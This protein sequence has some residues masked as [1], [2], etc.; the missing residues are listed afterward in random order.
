MVKSETPKPKNEKESNDKKKKKSNNDK[1]EKKPPND[2]KEKPSTKSVIPVVTNTPAALPGVPPVII[3]TKGILKEVSKK[4]KVVPAD[5]KQT[6][7]LTDKKLIKFLDELKYSNKKLFGNQFKPL[8]RRADCLKKDCPIKFMKLNNMLN[9]KGNIKKTE[10]DKID[11]RYIWQYI[12]YLRLYNKDLDIFKVVYK[13]EE[14][15]SMSPK[16]LYLL[17][18][19]KVDNEAIKRLSIQRK[20]L[21]TFLSKILKNKNIKNPMLELNMD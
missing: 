19:T 4:S 12:T 5:V 7:L 14:Y 21:Q 13:G 8:T 6:K 2:K 20:S 10:I 1:N 17:L 3:N 9:K 11:K 18:K 15:K 16:Y